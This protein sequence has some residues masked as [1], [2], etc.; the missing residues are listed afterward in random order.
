MQAKDSFNVIGELIKP[1]VLSNMSEDML[2]FLI[3]HLLELKASNVITK[4][5]YD[6]CMQAILNYTHFRPLK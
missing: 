4:I 6:V 1:S 5:S 3:S 2:I